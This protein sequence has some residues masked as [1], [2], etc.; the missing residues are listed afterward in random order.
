MQNML[1]RSLQTL[2]TKIFPVYKLNK[3]WG[4]FA[5]PDLNLTSY[6]TDDEVKTHGW[7]LNNSVTNNHINI[8]YTG[9]TGGIQ[10]VWF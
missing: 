1:Q 3:H 6:D 5:G 10:Y 2:A 7:V 4:L 8:I 9:I